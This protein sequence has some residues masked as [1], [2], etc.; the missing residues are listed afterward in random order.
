M[1]YPIVVEMRISKNKFSISS[2]KVTS[3]IRLYIVLFTYMILGIVLF[4]Y[5]QFQINSDGIEYI[6][7][8]HSYMSGNFNVSINDYWSPLFSW[9]LIPF[10]SFAKTPLEGLQVTKILSLIV[11]FFT[12]IGL[13]QLSYRFEMDELVRTVI[14]FM[15][16]PII[17]YFALSVITPDLLM[18]CVL[19][20]YLALIFDTNYSNKLFNGV[21]CGILGAFAY[22]TK[23]YGFTFFIATFLI[24][25]VLQY[26][27]DFDKFLRKKVLK[28]FV[29]GFV[30][31]MMISGVWIGLISFND[32]NL[33]IGTAGEY[34]HA[35]V[36]PLSQGSSENF[37]WIPSHNQL[38]PNYIP[39]D[40]SP[41]KSLNNFD[42]QLNLIWSNIIKVGLIITNFSY[43]SL[44]IILVYVIMYTNPPRKLIKKNEILY[45][46]ITLIISASGYV[47]ITVEA[48][49][50]WIM[51]ILLIFMGG[52]LI[53]LLFKWNYFPKKKFSKSIKTVVLILF[54]FSF[55]AMPLNYLVQNVHTDENI[56]TS[57]EVLMKEG[58]ENNLASNN[59]INMIFLLYYMDNT[60][61]GQIP[62]SIGT[63]ELINQLKNYEIDYYFVWGNAPNS[64]LLSKYHEVKNGNI[65]NLRIYAIK[66]GK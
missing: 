8:A 49:Y 36:G 51:Y 48:R 59:E 22:L 23:S 13:R 17:V 64:T 26:F 35:L 3:D 33:T 66:D 37:Q 20:Y 47:A 55:V 38:N 54:A 10:L 1:I 14:L 16:V 19:V 28:N 63:S 39:V 52:Y 6:G 15:M 40:W 34:N 43:L 46:L 32:K 9:L 2:D 5:Y 24:F 57:S 65:P 12:I 11:G 31:F 62:N 44:L 27:R 58:I 4:R 25:N 42:Y 30:I 60:N 7:I 45:P 18:V 29:V 56:Y 41:F 50:L 61:H 53:N 21:L